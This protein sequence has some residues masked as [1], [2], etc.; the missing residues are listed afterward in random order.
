VLLDLGAVA[1][2][3]AID[4]AARELQSCDSFAIDAGGDLYLRGMNRDGRPWSVGIRH[5]RVSGECIAAVQV[6]DHAVCTSGDYER[7]VG[8]PEEGR[9]DG[10]PEG[11]TNKGPAEAGHYREH[12]I[13]DPRTGSSPTSV[14]SVTVIAPS[15]MLADA[16][17]TAVFV[18]GPERGLALLEELEVDGLIIDGRLEF[19]QTTGWPGLSTAASTKAADE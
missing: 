9:H 5:P 8:P 4:L 16:L 13:I 11:G 2:G 10:P 15:A 14:V 17:A 6:T 19:R 1:K 18:L 7:V 12:H 3:L